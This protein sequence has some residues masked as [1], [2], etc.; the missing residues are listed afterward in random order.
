MVFTSESDVSRPTSGVSQMSDSASGRPST[1]R[2]LMAFLFTLLV[3]AGALVGQTSEEQAKSA[4][5]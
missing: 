4:V 5:V 3:R 2:G 1:V